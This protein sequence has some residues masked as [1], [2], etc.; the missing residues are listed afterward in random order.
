[1]G[2]KGTPRPTAGRPPKPLETHM[3]NGN[4]GKR[5]LPD[6]IP[7]SRERP[8]P[9]AHYD[10]AH[11][12]AWDFFANAIQGMGVLATIDAPSLEILVDSWVGYRQMQAE[13]M[14]S[15]YVQFTGQGNSISGYFAARNKLVQQ[16]TT[17]LMQ[18]G[19]SPV[20]RARLAFGQ[21][22][23]ETEEDPLAALMR[24][25]AERAERAKVQEQN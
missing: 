5:T 25:R 17:L 1:M 4:P 12:E 19:F 11:T 24:K 16:V 15:G 18:F 20:A 3:I 14:K 8:D 10:E 23:K 6:P 21:Q 9:P 7:V 2:I 13:V 22:K